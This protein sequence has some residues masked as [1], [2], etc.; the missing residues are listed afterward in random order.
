MTFKYEAG[1]NAAL[2]VE[3][4]DLRVDD[5]K[6][7]WRAY[8]KG[9]TM[10]GYLTGFGPTWETAVDVLITRYEHELAGIREGRA[11]MSTRMAQT[12]GKK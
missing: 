1:G 4:R 7:R 2:V 5:G 8:L 10:G 12:K 6:Y 9:R 11:E 3:D